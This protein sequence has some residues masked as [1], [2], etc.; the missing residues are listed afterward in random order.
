MTVSGA[1]AAPG[2]EHLLDLDDVRVARQLLVVE[3]LPA[4]RQRD[5]DLRCCKVSTLQASR[6]FAEK[7]PPQDRAI[8]RC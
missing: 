6:M 1:A 5:Q 2:Q 8:C 3:Q 7:L 4:T